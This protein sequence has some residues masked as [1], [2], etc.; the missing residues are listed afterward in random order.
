MN[1][2][3]E[4]KD[5]IAY[6]EE[7]FLEFIETMAS[8]LYE[9][10]DEDYEL[11]EEE[12]Y[13]ADELLEHF[14]ENYQH[15]TLKESATLAITGQRDP[16]QDLFEEFI[17]AALD[18]SI[19]GAVAGVVHGIKN[20]LSKRKAKKAASAASGAQAA[21]DKVYD[22]AQAAK[23]AAKGSSGLA[24]TFKKAK[25]EKLAKRRD[26]AFDAA[27]AAHGASKSASAA[28]TSGLKARASL[29]N[30]IDTGIAKAK[31]KVKAKVTAGAH[32]VAAAAGRVA[33]SL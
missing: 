5:R 30:R 24:G 7:L 23:K 10:L 20:L 22:K 4:Q 3:Q 12:A 26:T 31:E 16:N 33:G 29:K 28:H 15:L 8:E 2:T 14:V 21:H 18:E 17:E 11:S 6:T 32:K 27:N 25:A 19:G 1:L 13:L 9:D